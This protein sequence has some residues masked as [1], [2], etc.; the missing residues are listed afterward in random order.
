MQGWRY[1]LALFSSVVAN[2]VCQHAV[3]HIDAWLGA[4]SD[5]DPERRASTFAR[6][7]AA[8]VRF[9][10][11]VSTVE[12]LGDLSVHL[13]AVHRFMRGIRLERDGVVRRCHSVALTDWVA[14][15]ADGQERA[16]GTNVF[17]FNSD[18]YVTSVT[19]LWNQKR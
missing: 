5:P 1:Q 3:A 16:R 14:R 6:I 10:D 15:A 12:G 11:P 4:W 8:D 17:L 13:D 9:S 2:E 7:T 19:G 18:G